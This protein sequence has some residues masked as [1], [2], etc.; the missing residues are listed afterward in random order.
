MSVLPTT[1]RTRSI[2]ICLVYFN[3]HPASQRRGFLG[4]EEPAIG[5]RD[6]VL[7][8]WGMFYQH[9]IIRRYQ[10]AG[11]KRQLMEMYFQKFLEWRSRC[12]DLGSPSFKS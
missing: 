5:I 11:L 2:P 1:P 7:G 3:K 10:I 9:F 8:V 6:N 4:V 12:G